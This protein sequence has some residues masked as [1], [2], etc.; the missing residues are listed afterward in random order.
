M[1]SSRDVWVEMDEEERRAGRPMFHAPVDPLVEAVKTAAQMLERGES[2]A[3]VAEFLRTCL[4]KHP[5]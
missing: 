5:S 4:E 3:H 2:A 1:G